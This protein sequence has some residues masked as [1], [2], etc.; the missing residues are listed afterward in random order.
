MIGWLRFEN[1]ASQRS[2]EDMRY[3][4][5]KIFGGRNSRAGKPIP[6]ARYEPLVLLRARRLHYSEV[7]VI[8][9]L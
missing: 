4:F 3:A 6:F 5:G 2:S 1:E 8:W 9:F 7:F